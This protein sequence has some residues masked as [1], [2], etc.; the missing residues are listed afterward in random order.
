MR[1]IKEVE[2]SILSTEEQLRSVQ[3]ELL[4]VRQLLS[5][6]LEKSAEGRPGDPLTKGDILDMATGKPGLVGSLLEVENS[7]GDEK[8]DGK[9]HD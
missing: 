2:K 4:V 7:Q 1:V 5:R 8:L 9:E 3:E 6:L